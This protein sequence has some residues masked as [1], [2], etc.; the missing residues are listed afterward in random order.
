MVTRQADTAL[1]VINLRVW[2]EA[3]D[4]DVATL[5]IGA[6]QA[7]AEDVRREG[8]RIFR[9]AV[10][11]LIDEDVVADEQRRHHRTGRNGKGLEQHR[12]DHHRQNQRLDDDFDIF[13]E[14]IRL[15][16]DFSDTQS[17]S[18]KTPRRRNS[19]CRS[20]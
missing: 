12:T 16:F 19:F 3:E 14:G 11:E 20:L 4:D 2:R 10:S 7:A 8:Q 17:Y 13:P 1:D 15:G 9:I 5:R 6:E 18:F